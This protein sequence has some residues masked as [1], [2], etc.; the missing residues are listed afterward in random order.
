[1]PRLVPFLLLALSACG[2]PAASTGGTGGT[3]EGATPVPEDAPYPRTPELEPGEPPPVGAGE[4]PD[5]AA[6]DTAGADTATPDT[7]RA[8]TTGRDTMRTAP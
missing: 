8:D 3:P 2:G 5:A 4:P 7:A 6:P 1:M